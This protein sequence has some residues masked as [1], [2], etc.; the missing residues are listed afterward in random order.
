[1]PNK[2]VF[3]GTSIAAEYAFG[4]DTA[5]TTTLANVLI[6]NN[7]SR[8][9][10]YARFVLEFT[11]QAKL[12][13]GVVICD[14][15]VSVSVLTTAIKLLF[16]SGKYNLRAT[17]STAMAYASPYVAPLSRKSIVFDTVC[18]ITPGAGTVI[19]FRLPVLVLT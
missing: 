17:V 4:I 8:V 10:T 11:A 1:V 6:T 7:E 12:G 14:T 13:P 9:L 16:T 5:A 18:P 15:I 19:I 3:L 2:I